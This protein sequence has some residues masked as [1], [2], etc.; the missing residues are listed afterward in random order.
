MTAITTEPV[1]TCDRA[2][3]VA[4]ADAA[5]KYQR[6]WRFRIEVELEPD[7]WH[8]VYTLRDPDFVGGGP[9]YVI[10]AATGQIISKKYYQ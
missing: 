2:L 9:H 10:D 6:L 8:I 7:G 3:A 4:N 5:Q 1:V